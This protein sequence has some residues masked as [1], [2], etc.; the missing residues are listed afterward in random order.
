MNDLVQKCQLY[1]TLSNQSIPLVTVRSNVSLLTEQLWGQPN[2]ELLCY[3]STPIPLTHTAIKWSKV[4]IR[5]CQTTLESLLV[6]NKDIKIRLQQNQPNFQLESS[7]NTKP[8][9]YMGIVYRHLLKI[10]CISE[11]QFYNLVP[12]YF[13]HFLLTQFNFC[14]F[15]QIQICWF[16]IFYIFYGYSQ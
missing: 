16:Y 1:Y 2:L 3:S 7:T 12:Y 4:N 13:P 10:Q 9:T 15:L 11:I 14:Q 5:L 8:E 6:K